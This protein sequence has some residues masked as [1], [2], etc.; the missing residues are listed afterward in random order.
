MHY[1]VGIQILFLA[2]F[3]LFKPA[4]SEAFTK[5]K[6]HKTNKTAK[7]HK[8]HRTHSQPEV[9]A[10]I[11]TGCTSPTELISFAKS[12]EGIHYRYGSTNPEKGFDCSGFVNYVFNHFG[13]TIPRS[14]SDFASFRGLGDLNEARFGDLILFTGT[15][16]RRNAGHIGIVVSLPGEP[17]AF[18]HSTSGAANGVTQTQLNDYY[19]GR[20]MKIIRV[21]SENNTSQS[22]S[23]Y[24]ETA[25][26]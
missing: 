1:K 26:R 8:H 11:E 15:K 14:S 10:N 2:F 6:K 17:L 21:F 16:G 20:Y 4:G 13:I 22:D 25:A 5:H 3:S 23:T 9:D 12:L 24:Q 18:I 19:M 7:T